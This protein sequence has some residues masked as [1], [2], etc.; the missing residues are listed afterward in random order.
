MHKLVNMYPDVSSV[1][2]QATYCGLSCVGMSCIIAAIVLASTK[3]AIP[4]TILVFS[5]N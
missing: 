1:C 2:F 3:T 5:L 4:G